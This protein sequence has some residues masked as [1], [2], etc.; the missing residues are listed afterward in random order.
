[1]NSVSNSR[2]QTQQDNF[3]FYSNDA[4]HCLD[5]EPLKRKQTN[6]DF[7]ESSIFDILD[8]EFLIGDIVWVKFG[9]LSW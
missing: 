2:N 9:N 1:M 3:E 8:D 5:T 4:Q 7:L 6:D